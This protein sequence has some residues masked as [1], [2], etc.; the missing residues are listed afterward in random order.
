MDYKE[1]SLH[2]LLR[3]LPA[4]TILN[5]G[6]LIIVVDDE[7][8]V[9]NYRLGEVVRQQ[10]QVLVCVDADE[11]GVVRKQN[12]RFQVK[13]SAARTAYYPMFDIYR[14]PTPTDTL[15]ALTGEEIV[16]EEIVHKKEKKTKIKNVQRESIE[17]KAKKPK[18]MQ[19]GS[20]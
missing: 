18:K 19:T 20:V 15:T 12:D 11:C 8:D 13:C 3:Q 4:A 5:K 16:H 2:W 6:A 10:K 7:D 14:P 1:R 9:N 17:R